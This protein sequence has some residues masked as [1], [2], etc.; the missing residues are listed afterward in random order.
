MLPT[1]VGI[2]GLTACCLVLLSHCFAPTGKDVKSIVSRKMLMM[3]IFG[4][5]SD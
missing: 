4:A 3:R 2:T 5:D 1:R